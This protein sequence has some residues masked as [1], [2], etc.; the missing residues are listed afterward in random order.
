M[1]TGEV[2]VKVPGSSLYRRILDLFDRATLAKSFQDGKL[3]EWIRGKIKIAD[4]FTDPAEGKGVWCSP[5]PNDVVGRYICADYASSARRFRVHTKNDAGDPVDEWTGH[6]PK[7]IGWEQIGRSPGFN[8]EYRAAVL[9]SAFLGGTM[10]YGRVVLKDGGG[11]CTGVGGSYEGKVTDGTFTIKRPIMCRWDETSQ[12]ILMIEPTP[13]PKDVTSDGGK[14]RG[15][16]DRQAGVPLTEGSRATYRAADPF[17]GRSATTTI[18]GSVLQWKTHGKPFYDFARRV[19]EDGAWRSANRIPSNSPK[20]V[21][22][23]SVDLRAGAT[24]TSIVLSK[25]K[26]GQTLVRPGQTVVQ[27]RQTGT[28]TSQTGIKRDIVPTLVWY[29]NPLIWAGIGGGVVVASTGGYLLYR[30]LRKP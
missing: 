1:Y 22:A 7:A 6:G 25:A 23:P 24:T 12:T 16:T 4:A 13:R 21:D 20:A 14:S 11:V 2:L 15:E 19:L 5:L 3:H 8:K 27:P 29:K 28:G 17:A 10:P 18:T 30:K 26:P 9:A